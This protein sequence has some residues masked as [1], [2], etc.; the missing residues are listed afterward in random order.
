MEHQDM[1]NLSRLGHL[2]DLATWIDMVEEEKTK[3]MTNPKAQRRHGLPKGFEGMT[4]DEFDRRCKRYKLWRAVSDEQKRSILLAYRPEYPVRPQANP[5]S[6]LRALRKRFRIYNPNFFHYFLYDD[7]SGQWVPKLGQKG[8][9]RRRSDVWK[10][11]KEIEEC[12]LKEE[13]ERKI[14]GE[15]DVRVAKI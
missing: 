4:R 8:E 9:S 10:Y 6:G 14:E 13:G 3:K 7:Y 1:F 11:S 2:A 5:P 12:S 15:T